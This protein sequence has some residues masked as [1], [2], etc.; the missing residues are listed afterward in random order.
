MFRLFG[1]FRDHIPNYAAI[2]RPLTDLTAKQG[3][4]QTF[5]SGGRDAEGVEKQ[6]EKRETRRR[7][8]QGGREW[9]GGIPLPNRLGDLGSVVS[10]PSGVRGGAPAEND[11]SVI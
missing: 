9:G 5:S 6:D 7:R 8:R 3:R 11:F 1:Y 10:S 4:N 2:A